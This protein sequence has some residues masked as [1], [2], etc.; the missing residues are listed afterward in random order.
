M[1]SLRRPLWVNPNWSKG[2]IGRSSFRISEIHTSLSATDV[3]ISDG[4][5]IVK[6]ISKFDPQTKPLILAQTTWRRRCWRWRRRG[7][8][9]RGFEARPMMAKDKIANDT[10]KNILAA[11][12]KIR[13]DQNKSNRVIKKFVALTGGIV[14]YHYAMEGDSSANFERWV[15]VEKEVIIGI[16]VEWACRLWWKFE[17][18]N[19]H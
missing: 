16:W 1:E 12:C 9:W 10:F 19:R 4:S 7:R 13:K 5:L 11:N 8:C 17:E 2:T 6:L 18:E 14:S 15:T 3:T